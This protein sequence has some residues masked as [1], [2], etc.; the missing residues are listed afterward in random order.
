MSA[1]AWRDRA[2]GALAGVALGDALGMPAQTLP[3]ARIAA[4][5]GRIAGF[6]DPAPDHPVAAGLRAA[7]VT[8]DTEQTLLLARRLAADAPGFDEAA[9]AGD[10]SAWEDGVRARGLSDLLGPSTKAALAAFRSGAPPELCGR[11]GTTN[12]AAMRIAPVG[13]AVP[14]V[15]LARLVDRVERV[16]RLTH[17]TAEAIA[18][19][20]AVAAAVSA[21]VEGAAFE[22]ALAEALEAARAGAR[23]GAP[24]GERDIAGRILAALDAAGEGGEAAL[25]ARIGTSVAA[26]ESVPCAFGVVRLADGDPWAAGVIAANLGDD[27]DTI[28]AIAGA[29]AGACAGI[30]AFP[31]AELR[32]VVTVNGLDLAAAAAP[33]RELR[34][35]ASGAGPSP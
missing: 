32:R 14:P 27:T 25:A 20:A 10:L 30:A 26:A 21:G 12:G 18:A 22:A 19:A 13:I 4:L 7:Q 5:Y 23:R 16:S 1:A 6:V 2:L 8:D 24:A 31:P 33:L 29:I 9:W 11:A 28:G 3:R 15:P 35:A 17:N 34:A